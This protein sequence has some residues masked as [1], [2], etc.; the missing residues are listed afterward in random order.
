[1][2][3]D[4]EYRKA[5]KDFCRDNH[6]DMTAEE[7]AVGLKEAGYDVDTMTIYNL[8][9]RLRITPKKKPYT[10]KV[11]PPQ[12]APGYKHGYR[13]IAKAEKSVPIQR[14]K[15]EYSNT[16]YLKLLSMYAF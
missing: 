5:E 1:M 6:E 7:M 16:G 4:Q 8:C 15:G 3:N 14:A 13:N 2:A 10:R 11:Q 12:S 9:R